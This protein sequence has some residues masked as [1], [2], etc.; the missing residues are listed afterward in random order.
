MTPRFLSWGSSHHH[1]EAT[2]EGENTRGEAGFVSCVVG[3]D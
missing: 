2:R 3:G 1:G